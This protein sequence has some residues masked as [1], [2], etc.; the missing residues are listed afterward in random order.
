MSRGDIGAIQIRLG[1]QELLNTPAL[2]QILQNLTAP[3]LQSKL[4]CFRR[5]VMFLN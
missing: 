3:F 4:G 1:S 5:K 2:K